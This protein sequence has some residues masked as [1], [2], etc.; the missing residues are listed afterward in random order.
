MIRKL[1]WLCTIAAVAGAAGSGL[2]ATAWAGE[3]ARKADTRTVLSYQSTLKD[4]DN[5]PVAGIFQMVFELRKARNKRA[6]WKEKH[7]V[8]VDNGH[9]ALALGRHSALPRDL[10]PKTAVIVIT[11]PGIGE[12]LAESLS[13]EAL[14]NEPSLAGGG[15]GKRI[16][17]Y[18]EKAGFA[19][20]AEK[21]A[22]TDRLGN[23]TA[24][25]LQD[26]LDELQ[27]RK[28][29]VKVGKNHVNLSSVGGVGGTPF[30]AV[31]PPGM[32]VVGI[33]G[34]AGIYIDNFQVVCAPLE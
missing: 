10:D 4:D 9:Y 14:T 3:P 8:A 6:F 5:K 22:N 18:A 7:W 28:L 2:A 32:L 25:L 21:A 1:Q 13:G 31:C 30:E 23:F 11:M 12:V 16:V 19:Y 27:K 24:K 33:R 29:K 20:E 34:G 26:A 15:E 17:P